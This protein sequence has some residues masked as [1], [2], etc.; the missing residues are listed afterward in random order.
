MRRDHVLNRYHQ[1][2]GML[3]YV[4]GPV[5]IRLTEYKYPNLSTDQSFHLFKFQSS[6]YYTYN[7]EMKYFAVLFLILAPALI[8]GEFVEHQFEQRLMPIDQFDTRT[9]QNR[10]WLDDSSYTPGGPL[11]VVTTASVGFH[12]EDW[13][14]N[15]HFYDLGRELNALLLYTEHRFYGESRPTQ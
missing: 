7:S 1:V 9:W 11:F 8:Q 6:Q 10:Y 4:A 12:Y 13:L 3:S 15:T 5:L 2:Q 14:N